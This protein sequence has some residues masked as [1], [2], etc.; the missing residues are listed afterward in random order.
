MAPYQKNTCGRLFL[1]GILWKILAG[2]IFPDLSNE[3]ANNSITEGVSISSFIVVA[4]II[5]PLIETFFF[6][7]LP[8]EISNRIT[9]KCTGKPC[10][11]FSIVVS[12]LLF[13]VEH[14]FSIAYMLYAFAM[15]LYLAFFYSYT[16]RV[17]GK[18][19]KKGFAATALLHLLFNVL[20]FAAMIILNS[21]A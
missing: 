18:N 3:G 19:W 6:Q 14:R 1:V 7:V 13:A 11:L 9:K 12:A 20:A 8:I 5:V 2:I 21:Q 17:Y 15:G 16:S 10:A 4:L